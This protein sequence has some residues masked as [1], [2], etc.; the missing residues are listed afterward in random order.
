ML[1]LAAAILAVGLVA[2]AG[3]VMLSRRAGDASSGVANGRRRGLRFAQAIEE[4]P[5]HLRA[6]SR[7][8]RLLKQ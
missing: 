2:I 8:H 1:L 5:Q 4:R 3:A 7:L 6:E